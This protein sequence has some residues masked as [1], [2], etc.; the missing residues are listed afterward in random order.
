MA[1][2]DHPDFDELPLDKIGPRGNAWGR[3]GPDD[4]LGTLNYLNDEVVSQAATENIKTGTRLSLNWSMTGASNPKFA[5]KNLEL[6]LINKAPLKHAHD[7]EWSFNSQCSS[8]WDGFRH[9]AYQEEALYYMGRKA[10]E[11]AASDHPNS[12][13]HV[14]EKGIAG[15]AVFIDWYSWALNES[16]QIDGMTSHEIPFDQIIKTLEYQKMSLESL[17]A[18]DI[19]VIRFGYLAQY[20]TMDTTKREHLNELYKTQKPDNIG[21]K[22]SKQLLK[23]LWNTKIAAICGDARSLEVWPCKDLEWHLHEW[24]LAGWG[25]PIGELFYLEELSKK[26]KEL[27]RY[28]FFMS[29]SPM[30]VPGA[31][32]SPPNALAFF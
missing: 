7:D 14:S 12:I 16:I 13:H 4:Q 25:M 23:F 18:G 21:L 19:I 20:E 15:R 22:P 28:T 9:Y 27:G 32:A 8:Q 17:R 24:L 3:W 10:E 29:S 26:C 2:Q 31:V 11:F 1:F 30:N 5:R 6:K